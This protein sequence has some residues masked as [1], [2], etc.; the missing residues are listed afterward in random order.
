MISLCKMHWFFI[1]L[2]IYVCF[3]LCFVYFKLFSNLNYKL[4]SFSH[5]A[6]IHNNCGH[7]KHKKNHIEKES[8]LLRNYTNVETV[9]SY[10]SHTIIFLIFVHLQNS[11]C[12]LSIKFKKVD[13]CLQPLLKMFYTQSINT[14]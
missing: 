13:N 10:Y 9:Q 6:N 3:L 8:N 7:R 1:L 14:N 11:C 2:S 5:S 4:S 12:S